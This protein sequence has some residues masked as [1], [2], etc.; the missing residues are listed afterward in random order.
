MNC[1]IKNTTNIDPT[2]A[3]YEEVLIFVE[4]L[5]KIMQFIIV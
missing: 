4:F 5:T 3:K 2:K 1:R